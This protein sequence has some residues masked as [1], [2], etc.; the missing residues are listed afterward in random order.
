LLTHPVRTLFVA[1]TQQVRYSAVGR[2]RLRVVLERPDTIHME[3]DLV[4][5]SWISTLNRALFESA[6]RLDLTGG[7]NR[8]AEAV[9]AGAREADPHR[10]AALADAFGPKAAA[11]QRRLASLTRTLEL[12]LDLSATVDK[13][14]PVIRMDPRDEHVAWFD[15]ELRVAWNETPDELRAVTRY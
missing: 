15:P 14:Q 10:I 9:A 6:M 11:A 13:R 7:V 3:A 2:R 1:C 12:P 4:E 8:L 5:R